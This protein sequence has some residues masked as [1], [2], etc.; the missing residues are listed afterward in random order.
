MQNYL[1][2]YKLPVVRL[3]LGILAIVLSLIFSIQFVSQGNSRI[4]SLQKSIEDKKAQIAVCNPFFVS[5]CINPRTLELNA[6]ESELSTILKQSDS[7]TDA[8]ANAQ[9]LVK[10]AEY[11]GTNANSL[12]LNFAIASAVLLVLLGLIFISQY[13]A[14]KRIK[15]NEDLI[16]HI[17]ENGF[18]YRELKELVENYQKSHFKDK[19]LLAEIDQLKL[20][21]EKMRSCDNDIVKASILENEKLKNQLC[22]NECPHYLQ[23]ESSAYGFVSA[24]ILKKT[25]P[26]LQQCLRLR[27]AEN[28]CSQRRK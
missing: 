8:R 27:I 20:E 10:A 2:I 17:E 12:Q 4:E 6:L 14:A 5:K 19:D 3:I 21:N 11:L 13:T 23:H 28:L 15:S 18:P 1:N 22:L 25:L 24:S 26:V 16:N 9:L 7:L